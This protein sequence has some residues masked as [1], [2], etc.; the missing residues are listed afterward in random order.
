MNLT[1][2]PRRR[3]RGSA[4]AAS[5][6]RVRSRT[7]L[8]LCHPPSVAEHNPSASPASSPCKRSPANPTS[9]PSLP[10]SSS[11]H[12]RLYGGLYERLR[13]FPC[14]RELTD[15]RA[16]QLAAL[17]DGEQ[18]W[19]GHVLPHGRLL[20]V[21]GGQVGATHSRGISRRGAASVL[22]ADGHL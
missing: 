13:Y 16:R 3:W 17:V 10:P 11:P 1:S 9:R 20:R 6:C 12:G 19:D 5:G 21:G 8:L 18:R 14:R 4:S 15:R 7:P 22:R 2:T